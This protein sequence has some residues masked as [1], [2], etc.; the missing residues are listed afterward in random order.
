MTPRAKYSAHKATAKRRGIAFELTF[1]EWMAIWEASGRFGERGRRAHEYHMAR[2][3]DLGPY[4]VSNV[5]I[6]T[7]SQNAA[8]VK[9]RKGRKCQP[10]SEEHR[11]RLS[12]AHTG[13]KASA[14]TRRKLSA[15]RKG[16][17][18][19]LSADERM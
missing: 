1:E 8:E 3:G 17:K 14:E 12:E 15:L 18:M 6:I 11:R 9:N 2:H 7:T 19:N 4:T 13:K 16:V 10:F 5:K